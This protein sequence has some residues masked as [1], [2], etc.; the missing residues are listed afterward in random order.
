VIAGDLRVDQ[1][2]GASLVTVEGSLIGKGGIV[3]KSHGGSDLSIDGSRIFGG[4]SLRGGIGVAALA[5]LGGSSI[6][7]D[8]Q[9]IGGDG[10]DS[11]T[12]A[13]GVELMGQTRL[14]LAG[15]AD[16]VD[17][18]G[19]TFWGS[20][21]VNMGPGDDTVYIERDGALDGA[22]S[23]IRRNLVVRLGQGND[24]LLIGSAD[25]DNSLIVMGRTRL[26]LGPGADQM[27]ALTTEGWNWFA[28]RPV[29]IDPWDPTRPWDIAITERDDWGLRILGDSM[30]LHQNASQWDAVLKLLEIDGLSDPQ[31]PAEQT[32]KEQLVSLGPLS[33]LLYVG[34][35]RVVERLTLTTDDLAQLGANLE[36]QTLVRAGLHWGIEINLEYVG[37]TGKLAQ[38]WLARLT[39]QTFQ[40]Q[41]QFDAWFDQVKDA[42][43]WDQ[44]AG[45]FV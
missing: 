21:D 27:N 17:V 4:V 40:T 38:R 33:K 29:F 11:F 28:T 13:G 26:D 5:V 2:R 43:Q 32:V 24:E 9:V 31:V 18:Q 35:P 36:G 30:S 25:D 1:Y 22:I 19:T 10:D 34:F 37:T 15:G 6:G 41:A 12:S 8:V 39:G 23:T 7:G 3:L 16:Q 44:S 42:I 14:H 45:V 20:L